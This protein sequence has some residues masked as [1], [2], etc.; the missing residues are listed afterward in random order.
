MRKFARALAASGL[1]GAGRRPPWRYK[2][3][4]PG[5]MIF[6]G[7][8]AILPVLLTIYIILWLASAAESLFADIIVGVLP[9]GYEHWY[10]PGMGLAL[11]L[12]VLYLVGWLAHGWMVR[13]AI[14]TTESML[15]RIP[16]AKS[17]YGAIKDFTAFVAADR[18]K[19]FAQVVTINLQ[20]GGVS[21]R[22]LGFVTCD[23]FSKLP[24]GLGRSGE[25]AVY[26]PMSYQIGGYTVVV[27][28]EAVQPVDMSLEDAM[29]Y[30]VT[31]GM[32]VEKAAKPAAET[33]APAAGV[34]AASGAAARTPPAPPKELR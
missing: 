31:A 13:R 6:R 11:A 30:A 5:R 14:A 7:L 26:L 24:E 28:R 25:V 23:D 22:M 10:Y 9:E 1:K 33:P 29:R 4:H 34:G 2:L 20:V 15:T 21:M 19:Q 32:S 3:S 18:S 8:V 17:V 27:P 16:I 12:V